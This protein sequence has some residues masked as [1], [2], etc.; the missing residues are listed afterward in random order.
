MHVGGENPKLGSKLKTRGEI[1]FNVFFFA[2]FLLVWAHL[3]F[4]LGT[5][6][7]HFFYPFFW[8]DL[9]GDFLGLLID[10]LLVGR[11]KGGLF[12]VFSLLFWAD[13][14]GGLFGTFFHFFF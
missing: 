12:W 5:L 9:N 10:F 14:K 6:L 1:C 7:E 11:L 4:F 2:I 13:S 3:G 8:A